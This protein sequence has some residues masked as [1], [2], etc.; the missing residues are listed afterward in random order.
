MISEGRKSFGAWDRATLGGAMGSFPGNDPR[1]WV[2]FGLVEADGGADDRN[3]EFDDEYGP[4]VRVR[5]Q[6]S[7]I[8]VRCRVASWCAGPGEGAWYPFT[9]NDEVVVIVPEG[10]ESGGCTIIGRLNQKFDRFPRTVAGNDVTQNNTGFW[11][12]R[13]PFMMESNTALLFRLSST[14]SFLALQPDGNVVLA[15]GSNAFFHIGADFIGLQNGDGDLVLQGSNLTKSWRIAAGDDS[16]FT[17][18]GGSQGWQSGSP[19]MLAGSAEFPVWHAISAESVLLW[20]YE[21]MKVIG[22][23]L[24]TP[25]AGDLAIDASIAGMISSA[26]GDSLTVHIPTSQSTLA[27]TVTTMVKVPITLP[28]LLSA[29]LVI[30]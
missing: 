27:G 28:G 17:V 18:G 29:G 12:M 25:I 9:E 4:L 20:M 21:M 26:A 13:A 5:L 8:P 2:S 3:V 6:P 30:G 15:D 23:G 1:Q 22:P 10:D 24:T 11:K 16:F 14:G 19:I 7:D